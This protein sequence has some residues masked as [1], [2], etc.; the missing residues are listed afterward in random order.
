MSIFN[1]L[2][3]KMSIIHPGVPKVDSQLADEQVLWRYMDLPSFLSILS[4]RAIYFRR[5]D[6][7][8]D[9]HEGAFTR[10]VKERIEK[11][12][13]SHSHSTTYTEFKDKL[14]QRV[15]ISSWHASID[16]SMAMWALYGKGVLSVAA[17]T[18]VGQLVSEL[19][20]AHI[21]HPLAVAKVKYIKHWRNP[22]I[23]ISPY[24]NVFKYKVKAYAFEREVRVI[25]DKM[26][27]NW[28]G[29]ISDEG[30]SI[31]VRPERLLRSVV[32]SPEAPE[33]FKCL[34]AELI[35]KFDLS[36][37]LIRRSKLS[38]DPL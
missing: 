29:I 3:K 33:W 13:S 7:F 6:C 23:S 24:S 30:I 20:A 12:I 2:A 37:G 19:R 15:F 11:A 10:T 34:V 27:E 31:P 21:G 28:D 17:T 38:F 16:D 5:G 26:G 1:L 36:S 4:N 25:I 18:T 9:K 8:S 22:K 32:V 35:I 14:R